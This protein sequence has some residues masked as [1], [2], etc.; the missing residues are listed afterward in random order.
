MAR[1]KRGSV[2]KAAALEALQREAQGV[3]T[4]NVWPAD[5]G[6]DLNDDAKALK[7]YDL[8]TLLGERR[9]GARMGGEG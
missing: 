3:G 9:G 8:P 7:V 1:G 4:H 5:L 6:V 2:T